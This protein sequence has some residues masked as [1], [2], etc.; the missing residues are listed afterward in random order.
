MND[1][2]HILRDATGTFKCPLFY[3][4]NVTDC[5]AVVILWTSAYTS[6]ACKLCSNMDYEPKWL[7][8][9]QLLAVNLACQSGKSTWLA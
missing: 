3:L 5:N 4:C 6:R 2:T 1:I 7:K 9:L 8:R